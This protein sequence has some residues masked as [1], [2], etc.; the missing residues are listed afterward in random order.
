[1]ASFPHLARRAQVT[2]NQWLGIVIVVVLGLSAIF[3]IV[4]TCIIV[5]RKSARRH[6]ERQ[7]IAE[8]ETRSLVAQ[9]FDTTKSHQFVGQ[10]YNAHEYRIANSGPP[11]LY[12]RNESPIELQ[13]GTV[14]G[15]GTT[16]Q[17]LDGY[18]APATATHDGRPVEMPA[19][20]ATR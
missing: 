11:D 19:P 15:P 13:G 17:Q 3:I 10:S 12:P 18:S 9:D 8:Q 6:R 2:T 1:M 20:A 4:V 16:T 7:M 14:Q 5:R